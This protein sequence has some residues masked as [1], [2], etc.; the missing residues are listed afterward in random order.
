MLNLVKNNWYWDSKKIFIDIT[1][2]L[3]SYLQRVV[4]L[5]L[6]TNQ[7]FNYFLPTIYDLES[8]RVKILSPSPVQESI[9]KAE[10]VFKITVKNNK[11]H[12]LEGILIAP[13][14]K[15]E[16]ID[17]K[18]KVKDRL[19]VA[20]SGIAGCYEYWSAEGRLKDLYHN[21]NTSILMVNY[22]GVGNS[23]G[24]VY[25]SDDL[26]DD[27]YA[28]AK[29]AYD[30]VSLTPSKVH[31][32]GASM[33]GA[34]AVHVTAKLEKEGLKPASVCVD[35]SYAELAQTI[36]DIMPFK[37][38]KTICRSVIKYTL[39]EVDS[40]SAVKEISKTK[41]VVIRSKTDAVIPVSASLAT[42]LEAKGKKGDFFKLIDLP[43]LN[44]TQWDQMKEK[45]FPYWVQAEMEASFKGRMR[46][47]YLKCKDY[48]QKI[49]TGVRAHCAPFS[50]K[51]F[52]LEVQEYK[53]F[54]LA[55]EQPSIV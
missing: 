3:Y 12:L 27:G 11:N 16:M 54:L 51:L 39:W 20:Y 2:R 25:Q 44:D 31:L 9:N 8:K 32:Y 1:N 49:R 36:H 13:K 46:I 5:A 21:Y 23:A 55:A 22:R 33:G 52:P 17:G 4:S 37:F 42:A 15:L 10:Q 48:I 18:P 43:A 30:E 28:I 47:Q 35:R 26:L 34:V 7:R 14:D 19:F 41:L 53:K 29:Y 45:D 6:L 40:F 50:E 24:K 38:L